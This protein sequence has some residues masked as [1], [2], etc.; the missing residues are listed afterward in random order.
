[1]SRPILNALQGNLFDDGAAAGI[2]GRDGVAA[3]PRGLIAPDPESLFGEIVA[4]IGLGTAL[5]LS[6]DLG[7]PKLYI[8]KSPDLSGS[9][10][11]RRA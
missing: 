2:A 6:Q 3:I 8:P 1:M 5:K 7:G 4:L 9:G 10:V 11:R